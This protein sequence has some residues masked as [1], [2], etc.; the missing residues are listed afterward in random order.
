MRVTD[1]CLPAQHPSPG[2]KHLHGL[3]MMRII[4]VAVRIGALAQFGHSLP[5]S[6]SLASGA[7]QVLIEGSPRSP[8]LYFGVIWALSVPLCSGCTRVKIGGRHPLKTSVGCRLHYTPVGGTSHF[9]RTS[10]PIF[11]AR[12][13]MLGNNT[14]SGDLGSLKSSSSPLTGVGL[15]LAGQHLLS[16]PLIVPAGIGWVG[17]LRAYRAF[18]GAASRYHLSLVFSPSTVSCVLC[19]LLV[20]GSLLFSIIG[21]CTQALDLSGSQL[22]LIMPLPFRLP[23]GRP[24]PLMLLPAGA[25]NVGRL[26]RRVVRPL[27]GMSTAIKVCLSTRLLMLWRVRP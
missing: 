11:I 27:S 25:A 6:P 22:L 24:T 1:A 7:S 15:G 4:L 20:F 9:P 19:R 21:Q 26:Y 3:T 18:N 14:P 13:T 8:G 12:I 5:V 17:S 23:R 10:R 2:G 16:G